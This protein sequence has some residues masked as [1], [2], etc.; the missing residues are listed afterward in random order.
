MEN[1]EQQ[2]ERKG[3][4]HLFELPINRKPNSKEYFLSLLPSFS[5]DFTNKID[6][7]AFKELSPNIHFPFHVTLYYLGRLSADDLAFAIDWL[8]DKKPIQSPIRAKVNSVSSFKKDGEDFV[9]FLDL[10]SEEIDKLNSELFERFSH[11]RKDDFAFRAHMTLFY[12]TKKITEIQRMRLSSLFFD[13]SEITFNQLALGSV[14]NE[15]I[16]INHLVHLG[17]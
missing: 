12:P 1:I 6:H 7:P 11:L 16:K 13:I 17:Q 14:F 8:N 15:E 10:L 3:D 2:V 4:K 5:A 9:Y